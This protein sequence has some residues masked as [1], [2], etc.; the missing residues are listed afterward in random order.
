MWSWFAKQRP[1][2]LPM[3]DDVLGELVYGDDAWNATAHLGEQELQLSIAGDPSGP[4]P[5]G[6]ELLIDA[7]SRYDALVAAATAFLLQDVS[8][9]DLAQRPHRYRPTGI[10]SGADWQLRQRSITLTLEL[11][12]DPD[13][14]WRVEIGPD[15]PLD[16]GRDS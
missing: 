9:A 7:L 14:L 16:S 13:G 1:A 4:D 3:H 8:P 11:D 12:G 5:L 15:G 2:P 6:R 10:W